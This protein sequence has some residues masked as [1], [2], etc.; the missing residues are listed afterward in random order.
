MPNLYDLQLVEGNAASVS[1]TADAT[2]F[3]SPTGPVSVPARTITL[4]FDEDELL[5]TKK[6][7]GL[8]KS[9]RLIDHTTSQGNVVKVNVTKRFVPDTL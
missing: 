5:K 2:T 4:V 7:N 8:L 9:D 6:I 1:Y 3:N